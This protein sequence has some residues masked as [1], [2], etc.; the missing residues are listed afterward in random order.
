MK[1]AWWGVA[2]FLIVLVAPL[3][4]SASI[5]TQPTQPFASSP[6]I[7]ISAYGFSGSVLR[8]VQLFNT[9]S[10]V[11]SLDGWRM[12]SSTKPTPGTEYDYGEL[13]GDMAP[14]SHILVALPDIFDRHALALTEVIDVS[15][16]ASVA[17]IVLRSPKTEYLDEVVSVPAITA[18]TIRETASDASVFHVR[19]APSTSTGNTYLSSF[20]FSANADQL[21]SDEFYFAPDSSAAEIVEI[22]PDAPACAPF[23][24]EEVCGDYVKLYNPTSDT[25][26]LRHYRL[27]TGG[28]GQAISN[29][30]ATPLSGVMEPGHYMSFPIS[31][32]S[33]G[34]WVWIEDVYG[35]RSYPSSVAS[36][37]SSTG[38][39]HQ[40]WSYDADS[41]QWRWTSYPTP[42]DEPNRFAQE[43]AVNTCDGLLLSE[44]VA[45]VATDE[46]FIEVVNVADV[47]IDIG[48]CVLQTNRSTT[49][50]YIFEPARLE[51]GQYQTVSIEAT[52][53]VLTKTTSGTVYLLSSDYQLE[54]DQ[55]QY[56][57]L[58]EGVSWARVGDKWLQT[59]EVS[60]GRSNSFQ[61]YPSCE[62]GY[63]R[64]LETGLCNKTVV[65][66]QSLGDCGPGKYRNPETNR[67][68]LVAAAATS[69]TA[70]GA[71]KYRNPETNRCRNLATT[72]T[73]LTPCSPGQERN[74]LTNRCRSNVSTALTPCAANQE[75]NPETNRC[76]G[77]RSSATADF[78]VEVVAQT[79]QATLGWW[80][81]GGVGI[82][83][84][85]YAGWE[86]RMEVVSAIRRL[87]S[88]VKLGR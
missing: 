25:I 78:P 16:G 55:T 62:M 37:P 50:S 57:G 7:I 67:C 10:Q 12:V 18:S 6:P 4:A 73:L 21:M 82:L 60:P 54:V 29:T 11:I 35:T 49:K 72:A 47:A 31:M 20:A 77:I 53:L 66:T 42:S 38:Y 88:F 56:S 19:R 79:G 84:G 59:Y 28:Y 32:S 1:R 69:L 26:D 63:F 8:Y 45:N 40:A 27:R 80:A 33:S 43:Q 65:G 44:V 75:R 70:C 41:S 5:V 14:K 2:M 58:D 36:F 48:G 30:N 34:S 76:R 87:G 13:A 23:E 51:A 71:G 61:E 9:S 46:Q 74:P 81:F 22:Y 15:P 64:N 39:D 68:R 24:S 86:W 17:G 83:A 85:A 3:D 52:D